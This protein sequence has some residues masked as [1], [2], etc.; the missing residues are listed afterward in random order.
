MPHNSW[1]YM[2]LTSS[3]IV[4]GVVIYASQGVGSGESGQWRRQLVGTPLAFE[5]IFFAR[6]YVE[7]T[8]LVWFGTMPNSNSALF[9]QPYS[10]WNDAITGY[11]GA[12][13]KI[14]GLRERT[15]YID[16]FL[17]FHPSLNHVLFPMFC[18]LV[19]KECQI[20]VF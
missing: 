10:L 11:N 18:L 19:E 2:H 15:K 6:L 9:I 5:I 3:L 8:C 14:E 16:I 1:Y 4:T 13:A 20:V 17:F 7:T 12:C